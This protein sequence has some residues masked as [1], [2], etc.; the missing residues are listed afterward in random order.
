VE[1]TFVLL[2]KL[3]EIRGV[4]HMYL[5]IV[6]LKY[7]RKMCRLLSAEPPSGYITKLCEE[8]KHNSVDTC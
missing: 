3:A 4:Q 6:V 1:R 8:D 2:H 5:N 7:H